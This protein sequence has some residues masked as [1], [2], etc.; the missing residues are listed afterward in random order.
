MSWNV[1]LSVSDG[2]SSD[3][4]D[5]LD[6]TKHYVMRDGIMAP[7]PGP[8]ARTR[9]ITLNMRLRGSSADNLWANH[10][11]IAKKLEQAQDAVRRKSGVGVTLGVKVDTT[12]WIYFDVLAGELS[13]GRIWTTGTT[14]EATLTLVCLP[15]G[16]GDAVTES[17]TSTLTNGTGSTWLVSTIKGDVPSPA[18][19]TIEDVSTGDAVINGVHVFSRSRHGLTSGDYDPCLEL[20]AASPGFADTDSSSYSGSNYAALETTPTWRT[21]AEASRPAGAANDGMYDVLV[22]MRNRSP[23]PSAPGNLA[24]TVSASAVTVDDIGSNYESGNSNVIAVTL[25]DA[26]ATGDLV[27]IAF[28]MGRNDRTVS[29]ISCSAAGL[30]SGWTLATDGV[31][32]AALVGAGAQQLQV[33]WTY[34]TAAVVAGHTVTAEW[35]GTGTQRAARLYRVRGLATSSPV[36]QVAADKEQTTT[37]FAT[38]SITTTQAYQLLIAAATNV[39]APPATYNTVG[40]WTRHGDGTGVG[41]WHRVVTSATSYSVTVTTGSSNTHLGTLL[42]L[43]AAAATV[44]SL[45]VGTWDLYVVAVST[46]GELSP[47]SGLEQAVVAN[48]TDAI[49]LTWDAPSAGDVASYRVYRNRGTGWGYFSTGSTSTSYVWT[50]ESGITSGDPALDGDFVAALMRVQVGLAGG[51]TMFNGPTIRSALSEVWEDV[52]AGTFQLPPILDLDAGTPAA[53]LL[54]VQGKGTA[55][56]D[57]DVAWLAPHDEPQL[58]ARYPDYALTTKRDWV[59][60]QRRDGRVHGR[61]YVDNTTTDAGQLDVL[62]SLTVGPGPTQIALRLTVQGGTSD[63]TD[64]KVIATLRYIPLYVYLRGT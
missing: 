42:S 40:S 37:N 8:N 26:V 14:A 32:N 57:V 6:K 30:N 1:V 33:Y 39:S 34:A 29:S 55:D 4:L 54:R 36:E 51:V 61:L 64:A 63:V 20:T 47:V 11:N 41:L 31:D 21:V 44:P 27:V 48:T 60:E 19:L 62:G 53:W 13:V 24:A 58:I 23:V 10:A 22:R 16:R 3:Y 38:N 56:L 12:N 35:S 28:R 9:T 5:L 43:K 2:Q 18:R 7:P 46:T 59:I 50:T 17:A 49:S 52:L 45:T 15:Y 25:T